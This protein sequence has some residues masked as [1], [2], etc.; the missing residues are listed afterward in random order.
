[1]LNKNEFE[2]Y[3]DKAIAAP[4]FQTL[5]NLIGEDIGHAYKGNVK[6]FYEVKTSKNR[7][8]GTILLLSSNATSVLFW[9]KSF[10]EILLNKGFR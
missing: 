3:F 9:P 8:K 2:I 4:R 6:L 1:M 7:I 5:P 10:I